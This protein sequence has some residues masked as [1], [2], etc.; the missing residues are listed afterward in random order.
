MKLLE[1]VTMM[2]IKKNQQVWSI[3]FDKKA[4]SEVSVK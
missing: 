4:G 3:R 2:D 1:I